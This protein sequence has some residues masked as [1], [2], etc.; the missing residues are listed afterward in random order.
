MDFPIESIENDNCPNTQTILCGKYT[1]AKGLCVKSKRDCNKRTRKARALLN[2]EASSKGKSFGYVV[3]NLGR[4]C[5]PTVLKLDFEKIN[6]HYDIIPD[7]FSLM[8]YNIWGLSTKDK[9]KKL[10]S[11]RK[12]LLLETLKESNAD[13]MCFQEMS[14][15]SYIELAEFIKSYKYASEI[16]YPANK[17]MRN[18]NVEVYFLSKYT[19]KRVAVYG[20][21][22]VL[23]YENSMCV[24]EFPNL[25]IFNLY[26]QAGSKASIGQEK[27]WIHFSR[28]RYD[29][30]DN[31]Y[32]M[33]KKRYS[34]NNV[35]IC[36][37][38]NFHLDGEKSDWPEMEIIHKLKTDMGFIDTYRHLNK[39]AGLSEDTDKNLMRFNQKLVN[40]KYRYDGILYKPALKSWRLEDSKLIGQELKYL[41]QKDS[42]WFFEEVSEATKQGKTIDELKGVKR[43]KTGYNLPINASDHFGVLTEFIQTAE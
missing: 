3:D 35:V 37:D 10:F 33:I 40:K 18:R 14:H 43:N 38:F 29:L 15:E 23:N 16:P 2:L 13:L 25:I 30:L 1:L 24:V 9:F 6:T 22:G 27:T 11:L 39:D 17:T 26:I 42:K 28:C 36:G 5:Y 4:G 20:L 7:T 41:N 8:T 34:R 32:N 12:N 19:P 21:P 31:V